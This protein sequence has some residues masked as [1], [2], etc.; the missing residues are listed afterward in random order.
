M[1][2]HILVVDDDAAIRNLV[3]EYLARRTVLAGAP[4]LQRL[5]A[6]LGKVNDAAVQRDLLHDAVVLGLVDEGME[7]TF[8]NVRQFFHSLQDWPPRRTNPRP[9]ARNT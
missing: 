7:F 2:A 5:M 1:E 8:S 6:L 3:R 9:A 4:G